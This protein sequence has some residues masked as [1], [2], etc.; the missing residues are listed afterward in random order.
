MADFEGSWLGVQESCYPGRAK[1]D[2]FV[3][4]LPV[5]TTTEELGAAFVPYGEVQ[6]VVVLCRREFT[7]HTFGHV[8]L[9]TDDGTRRA[10]Q[11]LNLSLLRGLML[12]MESTFGRTSRIFRR[13]EYRRRGTATL[14]GSLPRTLCCKSSIRVAAKTEKKT[15]HSVAIRDPIIQASQETDHV[16]IGSGAGSCV[17]A[18]TGTSSPL[19]WFV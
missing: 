14:Q 17:W 12:R 9:D 1:Y 10:I 15:L 13:C 19:I 18:P 6:D 2:I 7:T 4:N 11:K 16:Y 5:D 3:K 8:L